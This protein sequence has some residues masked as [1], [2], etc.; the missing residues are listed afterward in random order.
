MLRITINREPKS[1]TFELEGKLAGPWVAELEQCWRVAL[2]T[3]DAPNLRFNLRAVSFIDAAGRELL[4]QIYAQGAELIAAG[5]M[6]KAIVA[7]IVAARRRS[8]ERSASA[9]ASKKHLYFFLFLLVALALGGNLR[10]QEKPPIRLTLREAVALALKQNP[11]VQIAVLNLA[12]SHQDQAIARSALLPQAQ[13]AVSDAVLRGNI[14]T[15]LGRRLPGIPQHIG[16]F[17]VFQAGPQFSA[18][19]FD[20]TLWQR[21]QASRQGVRASEAQQHSVR[22]QIVLL[23]VSQYLGTL[24]ASADVRA[25]QSRVELAQALH[26]QAA[27]LQKSG[28]GTGIDTLRANVELQNEKQRLILAETSRKTAIYGLIRLLNL[29]PQQTV[30]LADELSFF[31][32]PEFHPAESLE[33]AYATRPEM[34]A[35]IA[36]ERAAHAQKR[37]ASESRL[38]AIHFGGGWSYQGISVTTG[39]PVYEYQIGVDMPLFTGGRI[40]AEISRASLEL[41]KIAQEREDLRNQIALEVKTAFANLDSARNEVQVANLGVT[42]AQE[43]VVQAR[44]RF[45]AGVANNIEVISAQDALARANDNQIAAL[46]RYNQARADLARAIGQMESLYNK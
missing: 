42:L 36:Q 33:H 24:R 22:E 45:R 29:A 3:P 20:L 26:D 6:T 34:Q 35:L 17:Q 13:L 40:H 38:P 14:E 27:D 16:P 5:C 28:V 46:Y 9:P 25:A 4:A 10:A 31:E 15:S 11:Q 39:V 12:Q 1:T 44:D 37:A 7:E 30:E 21:W 2:E 8:R 41:Q 43:E 23:V 32:T 18:P 19:V